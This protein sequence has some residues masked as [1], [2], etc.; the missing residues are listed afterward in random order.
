MLATVPDG[1]GN[2]DKASL[3]KEGSANPALGNRGE[4]IQLLVFDPGISCLC[5]HR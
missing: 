5:Q 2:G 4:R 3:L 1:G